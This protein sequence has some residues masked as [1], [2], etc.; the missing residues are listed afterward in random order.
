MKIARLF[1][2]LLNKKS[3]IENAALFNHQLSTM[4]YSHLWS[5]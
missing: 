1:A 5:S 4:N 2:Q 3:N